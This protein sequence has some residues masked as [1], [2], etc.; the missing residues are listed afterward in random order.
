MIEKIEK[1][2]LLDY[3]LDYDDNFW[4]VSCIDN[5]I[6]GYIVYK[7]DDKGN[8]Y[9]NITKKYYKKMTCENIKEL[10][11]YK[12][13]FKPNKH[14]LEIKESITG[15]WKK[16]IDVLNEIGIEDKDIG[17][18]GSTLIGF[19]LIK[20]IDFVIYGTKNLKLYHK[21][22]DY[23]KEKVGAT[24]ITKKHI[25][26]Q[27]DKHKDKYSSKTDLKEIISRNWSGIQIKDGV[28]STPRF[29]DRANQKLL[30]DSG[31]RKKVV[32]RVTSGLTSAMLPRW[33][34][35][36]YNNE[37]Y[38]VKT[39]LWKYQS[40]L[41]DGDVIE[42]LADV[43]DN[44]KTIT[45]HDKECYIKYLKKGEDIIAGNAIKEICS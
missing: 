16:Y 30:C 7:V 41:K 36:I 15:V 32:C 4:I 34:E 31:N 11:E 3:I 45:L 1:L 20:D 42:C 13:I 12:K 43:N 21:F 37:T 25:D 39:W 40:F 2:E 29:I 33:G 5:K 8:R 9:N 22:N 35:V 14:Y 26:Y 6:K 38:K 24:Y 17:I 19:D 23:I 27:Y 18:F 10:P 44:L 28:L